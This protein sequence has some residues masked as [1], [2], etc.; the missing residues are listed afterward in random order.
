MPL[1]VLLTGKLHG[2]DMGASV[3]LLHRAE[4]CDVVAPGAGFVTLKE[5]FAM[6]RQLDWEALIKDQLLLKSAATISN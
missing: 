1:R 3:L 2:P 5:R 4:T 6:L